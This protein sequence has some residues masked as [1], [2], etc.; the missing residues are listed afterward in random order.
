MVQLHL[1]VLLIF[2]RLFTSVMAQCGNAGIC[3]N[4]NPYN[5]VT[6]TR[7]TTNTYIRTTA[8]PPYDNPH[9]NNP[10]SACVRNNN[11]QIPHTPRFA[12]VPIPTGERIGERFNVHYLKTDPPPI[13]GAI[14]VLVNGVVVY[15]VGSPCGYRSRCPNEGGLTIY[16]DAYDSEGVTL[17]QCGGHP[18]EMQQ[19]YHIHT[20]NTFLNSTG[21]Q[22]CALPVDTPGEHSVLIGWMFDGFP[23]YGQ[24]SQG[25]KLPT[26]LDSCHGHTHEINGTMQYHY[27][28]PLDFPWM[29]G[30]FKGCP[31]VSNN[32]RQLNFTNVTYG[33]PEGVAT[34]PNP[35]YEDAVPVAAGGPVIS[36]VLAVMSV[37]TTM[38]LS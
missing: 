28:M 18:D 5:T 13:F 1:L 8:C 35:L 14:G 6:I 30:C 25:G 10:N 9:W 20:G 3:P 11:F 19:Q 4:S 33:C 16:V 26:Q 32:P 31:V 36:I 15:G 21:R 24:Y 37:L 34:D 22:K 7:D 12:K 23:L 29:I 38:T 27:H 2:F 17:D